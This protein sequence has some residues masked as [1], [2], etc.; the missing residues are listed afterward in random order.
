MESK[1]NLTSSEIAFLWTSYMNE[2]LSKCMLGFM[3]KDIEDSDITTIIQNAYDASCQN[4]DELH[5]IF[6]EENFPIPSGFTENDVNMEAP[7]LFTDVFCLTYVNHMAKIALIAYSSSLSMSKRGDIRQYFTKAITQSLTQYNQST[8]ISL[9][10]GIEARPPFIG[11]PNNTDYVSDKSYLRGLNPFNEKRPLNAVEISHLHQNITTNSIGNKLC[12]AFA[13]TSQTKVVQDFMLRNSEVSKKH[14]TI[15]T[16]ILL[17]EDVEVGQIPDT[18]VSH[19]TTQTFSDKLI[20]FHISLIMA[21]GI[22]NYAVAASA[23]QRSDLMVNYERLSLEVAK[24]AKS[25]ADIMIENNWFEQPPGIKNRKKLAKDK[26]KN[27]N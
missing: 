27:K 5:A 24:L 16:D 2:S 17:K 10:K 7:W 12:L 25:G 14:I 19:S 8:D 3:L 20:M 26:N 11:I 21:A 1:V 22:G 15:F 4:L 9:L 6:K 13:Q 18:G 23:S